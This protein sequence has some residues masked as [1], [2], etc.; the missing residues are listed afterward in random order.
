MENRTESTNL[1]YQKTYTASGESYTE[2]KLAAI[3]L[4]PLSGK[5]FLDL[6]CNAGF[7]CGKALEYGA[8]R[9]LGIDIDPKVIQLARNSHPG[10]EFS[11]KGWDRFPDETFDIIICLS[12]IHYAADFY[13]FAANIHSHLS[14]DGVFILEGGLLDPEGQFFT[15]IPIPVWRKVGD[16]C[17]HLSHGFLKRHFLREFNWNIQGES[18]PKNGDPI[19]RFLIHASRGERQSAP[20]TFQVDLVE[21]AQCL[22]LSAETISATMP[23]YDYIRQLGALENITQSSIT[24]LLEDPKIFSIFVDDLVFAIGRQRPAT[25]HL[26]S[27]DA[28]NLGKLCRALKQSGIQ[29][30]GAPGTL[31]S[32]SHYINRLETIPNNLQE[33]NLTG[34]SVAILGY[35]EPS[36]TNL[37]LE[38][39]AAQCYSTQTEGTNLPSDDATIDVAFFDIRSVPQSDSTKEIQSLLETAQKRLKPNG[40]L[41][42]I[43]Q[44]GHVN[45]NVDCVNSIVMTGDGPMPSSAYLFDSILANFAVRTLDSAID[46]ES[47]VLTRL[48]RLSRKKPSLLLILAPSQSGKTTLAR[49]LKSR[50]QHSHISNDYV[51]LEIVRLKSKG[52]LNWLPSSIA[53]FSD[54]VDIRTACG[55]FNR[56]LESDHALL[57]DYLELV[58]T[59]I[60]RNKQLVSI[61]LDLRNANSFSFVKDFFAANGF[62]VWMVSR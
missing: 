33:G 54:G 9:V 21:Y 29:V 17:R 61:D 40:V 23:S 1:G 26:R 45:P 38:K 41:F 62:S 27:L 57:K 8:T 58:V 18:V 19:P 14:D 52:M 42:C 53:D 44:S 55:L 49:D 51:F 10:A 35:E 16:R 24:S 31:K 25:I 59:L 32:L 34:K 20:D 46:N 5:R 15:D 48:L 13:S 3:Q 37:I 39:G 28:A 36:L 4:P 22:A 6:G 50:D 11:D 43:L 12:A 7:Y 60:P 2:S 56:R 30:E 47:G